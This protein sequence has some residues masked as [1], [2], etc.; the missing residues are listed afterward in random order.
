MEREVFFGGAAGGGKTLSLLAAALQFVETPGYS[1]LLLRRTFPDLKKPGCLIPLSKLLLTGK[2]SYNQTEKEWTFPS[3]AK[4]CFGYCDTDDDVYQYQGSQWS[5][6]GV[7]ELSQWNEWPYR[8][9]FSRLR[10]PKNGP[11]AAIPIRMRASG[12]PGGKGHT[13]CKNRFIVPGCGRLFVPSKIADNPHL[14]RLEYEQSL[15]ELDPITRAQLL[16]GDWDAFEGGRFSADW[17]REWY[18]ATDPQGVPRYYL[19]DTVIDGTGTTRWRDYKDWPCH[20]CWNFSVCDP[21][22][23]EDDIND[24]TCILTCAVTPEQDILCLDVFRK[25]LPIDK[26]VPEIA[27]VVG[28]FSPQWVGI[29]DVGFQ[30]GILKGAQKDSRIPAVMPLSPEGKGKLVRATGAI[31]RAEAGQIFIPQRGKRFPWVEDFVAELVQFTGDEDQDA[32]DDQVDC[33]A[34]AVQALDRHGLSKPY[35][36]TPDPMD[37]SDPEDE[38][39]DFG[40]GGM[41]NFGEYG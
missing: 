8:Y 31:I 40:G 2:A 19:G 14:D 18:A 29:E 38:G 11:L 37:G 21:A 17:F 35:L 41:F 32:H 20:L 33:L 27:R 30:V 10:R 9:L 36:V 39:E 7:D 34:Y 15:A 5:F 1:A 4:L 6:I 16:A 12:N 22:C 3:G 28:E 24:S 13:F 26:I 23:S 25:Q